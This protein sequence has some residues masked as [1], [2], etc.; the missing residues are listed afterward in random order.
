MNFEVF[1]NQIKTLFRVFDICFVFVFKQ[2]RAVLFRFPLVQVY[3]LL[4]LFFFYFVEW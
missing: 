1:G 4:L 3:V 2:N